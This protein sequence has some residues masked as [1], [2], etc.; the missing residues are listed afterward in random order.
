MDEISEFF[1]KVWAH[2][3]E[4]AEAVGAVTVSAFAAVV[5]LQALTATLLSSAKAL[6]KRA[7]LTAARWDDGA[8]KHL[9]TFLDTCAGGLAK[10]AGFLRWFGRKFIAPFA[11]QAVAKLN[12]D[13][14]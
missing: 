6:Q 8:A 10:A 13:P 9:V 11:P 3:A 1:L 14:E 7:A 5:A 2:R 4:I 12:K